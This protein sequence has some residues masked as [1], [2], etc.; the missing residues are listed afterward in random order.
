MDS[1]GRAGF[2]YDFQS[3]LHDNNP[4]NKAFCRV[5]S[6]FEMAPGL[7]LILIAGSDEAMRLGDWMP[8]LPTSLRSA[9]VRSRALSFYSADNRAYAAILQ[10]LPFSIFEGPEHAM[11]IVRRE[12]AKLV[13]EK[14]FDVANGLDSAH[15]IIG[16]IRTYIRSRTSL[17]C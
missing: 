2:G 14:T 9:S 6:V 10:K 8:T 11:G 17:L 12:T 3:L 5:L 4:I 15:D 13:A 7:T 1:V 16:V